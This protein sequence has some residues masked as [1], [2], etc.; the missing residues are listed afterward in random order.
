MTDLTELELRL[1]ARTLEERSPRVFIETWGV[2]RHELGF[3]RLGEIGAARL[4]E[5]PDCGLVVGIAS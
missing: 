1:E 3:R 4:D 2:C 5:C